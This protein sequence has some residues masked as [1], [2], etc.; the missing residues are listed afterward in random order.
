VVL[1]W[2]R[3]IARFAPCLRAVCITG[4]A[5]TRRDLLTRADEADVLITS[6]DML[7]RDIALYEP[8]SFH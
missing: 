2:E 6:Y 3:E 7:K 4:D 8:M 1:G 5:A